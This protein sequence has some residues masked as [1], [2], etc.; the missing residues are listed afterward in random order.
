MTGRVTKPEKVLIKIYYEFLKYLCKLLWFNLKNKL[1]RFS[2]HQTEM[3]LYA[4]VNSSS[5]A[6]TR[7]WFATICDSQVFI[8][9]NLSNTFGL[10]LVIAFT[11]NNLNMH[12]FCYPFQWWMTILSVCPCTQ[13]SMESK[14]NGTAH[15]HR[16]G[17]QSYFI[18]KQ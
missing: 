6:E 7:K 13:C 12:S 9:W 5:V 4:F 3:F 14:K 16:L 10:N 17:P 1:T 8:Y 11:W 18:K 2:G 15:S